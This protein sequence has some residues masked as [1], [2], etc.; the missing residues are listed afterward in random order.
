MVPR[1]CYICHT[2]S[3][4]FFVQT[5]YHFSL[6][7]DL[8]SLPTSWLQCCE[9]KTMRNQFFVLFKKYDKTTV[10]HSFKTTKRNECIEV[11]VFASY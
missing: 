7:F 6:F 8:L 2:Y 4:S 9:P 11:K 10:N 3:R 5:F 1:V